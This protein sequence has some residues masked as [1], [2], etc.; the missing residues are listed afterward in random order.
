[1]YC[2]CN[3]CDYYIF[4]IEYFTYGAYNILDSFYIICVYNML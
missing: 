4:F 1:M 2:K 3:Y